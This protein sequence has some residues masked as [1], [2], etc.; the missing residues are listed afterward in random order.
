MTGPFTP[1]QS[2]EIDRRIVEMMTAVMGTG[3]YSGVCQ[4]IADRRA[5]AIGDESSLNEIQIG[6]IIQA[7]D[8]LKDNATDADDVRRIIA[9]EVRGF[10]RK[11][12]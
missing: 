8:L 11:G 5:H 1:E 4:A 7:L 9:D 10:A 2:A 6:L 3:Q 12:R